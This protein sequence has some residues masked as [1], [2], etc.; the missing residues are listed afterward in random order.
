MGRLNHILRSGVRA[1][2]YPLIAG[3][4]YFGGMFSVQ[5]ICNFTSS[6]IHTQA[7]LENLLEI[8]RRKI[9]QKN[10]SKIYAKLSPYDIGRSLK[11]HNGEYG[12]QIGGNNATLSTLRHELYHILDG[13]LEGTA[14]S[15]K[16][17]FQKEI[18]D[19]K[20]YF[21]DEPKATAYQVT[22]LN[23]KF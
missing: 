17:G 9:D 23:S 7:Q 8:E 2:S 12:I 18:R 11:F 14:L 19:L 4:L 3:F 6:K 20:Y 21:W 16:I 22:G 1:I 10:G 15:S 5:T 13:H